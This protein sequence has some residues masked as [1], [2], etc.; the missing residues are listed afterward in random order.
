M[1]EYDTATLTITG[2][3]GDINGTYSL[4]DP[5]GPFLGTPGWEAGIYVAFASNEFGPPSFAIGENYTFVGSDFIGAPNTTT[6]LPG[7]V[8][9]T[10]DFEGAVMDGGNDYDFGTVMTIDGSS[11]QIQY[12]WAAVALDAGGTVPEPST[13]AAFGGLAALGLIALRRRRA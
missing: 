12:N 10:A 11:G 8:V 1:L 9:S 7:D 5:N 2:S 6:I 4:V 13:Y 3:T